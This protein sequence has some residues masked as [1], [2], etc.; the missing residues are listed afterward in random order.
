M[1]KYSPK[2]YAKAL[3]QLL[4]D[5]NATAIFL[6]FLAKN[7]DMKKAGQIISLAEDLWYKKT[8]ARKISVETARH[9][10][11][12]PLKDFLREGDKVTKKI[13]PQLIAGIKITVN[14]EKQLDFSLQKKLKELF[15]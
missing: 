6:D 13:N 3:V 9:I 5:E 10:E 15:T 8:A 1:S 4:P 14:G 11:A 2:I 12:N 7:G